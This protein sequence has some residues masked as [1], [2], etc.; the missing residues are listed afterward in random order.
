MQA[1]TKYIGGHSDVLLGSVTVRDRATWER[2]GATHEGLGLGASPDDCSLALRGMQTLAVRLS[3]IERSALEVAS[4]LAG[5]PE[6][7][8]V[9][10]PA[11]PSC[12]GHDIW[13]RDF[14]GSS[15]VFSFVFAARYGEADVFRVID[16]L[17]L[18]RIGYSWGGVT[19]L[20]VPASA[21]VAARAGC[22]PDRRLVR[23]SIGL[24]STDD[25]VADLEQALATLEGP[26][27]G[28][29]PA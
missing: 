3:A 8:R 2:V 13:K 9:L 15:G 28:G 5:R 25:L 4:W 29:R 7:D 27:P 12:P 23:L 1:L 20:V 10:H 6:V 17:R 24:E 26:V 21:D 22:G 14:S 16:A 11:L 18:F 19:S